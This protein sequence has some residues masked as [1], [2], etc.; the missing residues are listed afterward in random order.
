MINIRSSMNLKVTASIKIIRHVQI[1]IDNL[2]YG[3]LWLHPLLAEY[4]TSDK[5]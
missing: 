4:F 1:D 5:L 2:M 3:M